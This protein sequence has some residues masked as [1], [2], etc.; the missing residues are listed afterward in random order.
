MKKIF[1]QSSIPRSGS[2]L[3]QNILAQNPEIYAT[4]T[5][6]MP[7]YLS[8]M[9][10][11]YTNNPNV[12]AQDEN[13]MKMAFKGMCRESLQGYFNS[14]TERPY[15]FDKS[16]VWMP[17]YNFIKFITDEEPKIICMVRDLRDV[18]ASNEKNYRKNPDKSRHSFGMGE[19]NTLPKRIDVW[20]SS[21]SFVGSAVDFLN[22]A[23]STGTISKMLLIKYENFCLYPDKAMEKIYDYLQIPYY[24]HEFD[25]V[26]Q[27]THENDRVHGIFGVHTIRNSVEMIPS[28]ANEILG[29]E[30]CDWIYDKYKWYYDYLS[31]NYQL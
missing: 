10:E 27:L 12:I 5:S 22:D 14:L 9:R 23:I 25:N 1:Y 28:D 4:P 13:E 18:F 11:V 31:Y 15:I 16:R 19:A 21:D 3:L 20:A 30:I 6:P 2:T 17:N 24:K 8:M 26:P 29:K 7:D